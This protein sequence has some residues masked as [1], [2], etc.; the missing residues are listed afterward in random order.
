MSRRVT[1]TLD[2]VWPDAAFDDRAG[3]PAE[4][5]DT[6]EILCGVEGDPY[7]G[8]AIGELPSLAGASI[9][10]TRDCVLSTF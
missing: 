1:S 8:R 2:R 9:A 6:P 10:G 3:M 5:R 4:A 7:D